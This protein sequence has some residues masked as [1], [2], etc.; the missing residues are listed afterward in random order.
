MS[1]LASQK[2]GFDGDQNGEAEFTDERRPS[3][4]NKDK[5]LKQLAD[6]E[7]VDTDQAFNM[8]LKPRERMEYWQFLV[9][10]KRRERRPEAKETDDE[11][12]ER[13]FPKHASRI[14]SLVVSRTWDYLYI[15]FLLVFVVLVGVNHDGYLP[16]FVAPYL[17]SIYTALFLAAFAAQ[18]LPAVGIIYFMNY[19][20]LRTHF[21]AA[22]EFSEW[23]FTV[24]ILAQVIEQFFY[25]RYCPVLYCV[26]YCTV[27]SCT[28]YCTVLSCTV[29]CTVYCVLYC[30]VLY[31]TVSGQLKF[32][33]ILI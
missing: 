31:C 19:Q 16:P 28:V 3:P 13:T 26:L 1:E 15:L 5:D 4:R 6:I 20:N 9:K 8:K 25:G 23:G 29:P 11:V 21:R 7:Y 30:T 14:F 24:V 10:N 17:P 33:R 12:I 32:C 27:L 18:V 22:T 2:G